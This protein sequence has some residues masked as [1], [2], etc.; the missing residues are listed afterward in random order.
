MNAAARLALI[1]IVPV[2][3]ALATYLLMRDAFLAPVNKA[4]TATVLVEVEPGKTFHEIARVLEAKG[5]VRHWWS[6]EL[7]ARMRKSDRSINAGE[8]ELSQAMEPRAILKKLASGEVYRRKVTLQEGTSAWDVGKLVEAAGLMSQQDF[9]AAL[10]DP[11]LLAAAGLAAPSFEG[12]LFP[13]T[14]FFSRP[15]TAKE[16]V[17][18]MLEEGEK[19]WPAEFS[20]RADELQLSRQEIIT[21]A[22]IIEKESGNVEEQPLISSV[23]HNRLGQG[24]KLQ[25]DPTVI[26]GIPNFNGNL[27]R[28]DLQTPSPYNTYMNFGLPPGPI[29]NPGE[30]AIRAA[31]F[32]QDSTYLFF[33]ADGTG[34]HVFSTTLQEHN[35]AVNLYQRNRRAKNSAPTPPVEA[36]EA[37]PQ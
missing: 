22:S 21:L 8:Y 7:L 23:F 34:K 32:P 17:W 33:V 12:Y 11:K 28:E 9:D 6:L 37:T 35:E 4:S 2:L 24:M 15:I 36:E 18:R 14:Y 25:S 10:A 1:I 19:R 26:Y 30:T 5:V 27:T 13:E 29:C 16:V 3:V 31:L 20:N